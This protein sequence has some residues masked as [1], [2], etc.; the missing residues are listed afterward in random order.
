M[1]SMAWLV[2][3]GERIGVHPNYWLRYVN[4]GN[5]SRWQSSVVGCA[6][7]PESP[8]EFG[9]NVFFFAVHLANRI[10]VER[11]ACDSC[12]LLIRYTVW[13]VWEQSCIG[14]YQE[15]GQ[16][17]P[18]RIGR[19]CFFSTLVAHT[20]QAHAHAIMSSE[21]EKQAITYSALSF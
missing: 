6:H 3:H 1:W 5:D 19:K 11:Q 20:Q 14:H 21:H 18:H 12:C 15:I 9:S 8:I 10:Y 2:V 4:I 13:D 16:R 7:D 17:I